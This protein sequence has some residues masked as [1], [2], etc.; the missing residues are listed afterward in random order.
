M[1]I[2]NRFLKVTRGS[3]TIEAALVL[4][5][6]IYII[7]AFVYFLQ[8]IG[9]QENLQNAITETGFFAAKYAYVYDYINEYGQEDESQNE[10]NDSEKDNSVENNHE[11]EDEPEEFIGNTSGKVGSGI[12]EVIAKGIDSSYYKVKMQDYIDI[13]KIN[14]S[15]IENGFNGVHTYLSSF[16]KE[17]D[18]IDIIVTYN[19][20]LPLLFINID[21][22]PVMQ[23]VRMR[24]WNGYEVAA[25]NSPADTTDE[26]PEMVYITQTGTVYHLYKDCT[27]LNLSIKEAGVDQIAN[28]RNSS[29]GKYKKCS[30]C[31]DRVNASGQVYITDTGDRYHWDL[32]CSGLKRS[33]ITIP[34]SDV[35]DRSL[36]SRCAAREK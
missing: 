32:N 2:N 27:Y 18:A 34:K 17:D 22:I 30:L 31:G 29:G 20:K 5:V 4:P 25:K 1:R 15:C 36:C 19:I 9:I 11:T 21:P 3:L 8:I 6:F 33:I 12:E 13:Y 10:N 14:H 35:G 24:G 16:M 23:R 7:I 26:N 28:L